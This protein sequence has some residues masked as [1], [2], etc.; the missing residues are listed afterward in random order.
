MTT[1]EQQPDDQGTQDDQSADH[2]AAAWSDYRGPVWSA[3]EA[4]RRCNISRTTLTRRLKAGD[5]PGATLTADGWRIPA[6]GL[7][8]AG[9]AAR[10]APDDQQP[11][12]SD[13]QGDGDRDDSTAAQVADLTARLEVE[14]VRRE[15]AER[16]ADE[17]AARILDLQ[18]AL[19]A[20]APPPSDSADQQDDRSDDGGQDTPAAPPG[21]QMDAQTA[22]QPRPGLLAR[23][24]AA[25]TGD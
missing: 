24:R 5:I 25:I 2:P 19:R 6:Q 14:R 7:A 17:R 20:I 16:L 23:L 22:P 15:G 18:T 4:A 12:N 10:T 8:I 9:L 11:T 1:D 13:D 3:S 21:P